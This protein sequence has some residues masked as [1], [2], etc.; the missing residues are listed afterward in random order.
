MRADGSLKGSLS[1]EVATSDGGSRRGS[2]KFGATSCNGTYD[3][4]C[5]PH[6]G[7]R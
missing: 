2:L 5:K 6:E 3:R 1:E 4:L 7:M